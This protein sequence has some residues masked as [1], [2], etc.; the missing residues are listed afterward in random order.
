M[1]SA[2]KTIPNLFIDNAST[3]D[4]VNINTSDLQAPANRITFRD[5]TGAQNG[6]TFN[7]N[8]DAPKTYGNIS[9]PNDMTARFNG[10]QNPLTN[11]ST[12]LPE[13]DTNIFGGTVNF[14][15]NT[16][17]TWNSD[18]TFKD[19]VEIISTPTNV[20]RAVN[21]VRNNIFTVDAPLTFT[22]PGWARVGF[23]ADNTFTE[24]G[25]AVAFNGTRNI[26]RFDGNGNT[27]L[28][29][30]ST[31]FVNSNGGA[32]A[33]VDFRS[34][35]TFEGNVEFGEA[36]GGDATAE[37]FFNNGIS[38]PNI[39]TTFTMGADSRMRI[40]GAPVRLRD[41]IIGENNEITFNSTVEID[42]M[43]LSKFDVIN[44]PQSSGGANS[45]TTT[46]NEY[47]TAR[48]DCAGWINLRS[49]L[50][51]VQAQID[52]ETAHTTVGNRNFL[53]TFVQDIWNRDLGGNPLQVVQADPDV[54]SDIG[55]NDGITFINN[56]AS[57]TFYWVRSDNE[58]ANNQNSTGNWNDL[59]QD[60][61]WATSSGGNAVG[62]IPTA[63]D[64]VVFDDNSFSYTEAGQEPEVV[65]LDKFFSYAK[66]ITWNVTSD[67]SRARL[68]GD[69]ANTLQIFG[70]LL[71]QNNITDADWNDFEGLTEFKGIA[72]ANTTKTIAMNGARLNGPILFNA[73]NDVWTITDNMRVEGGGR[74]DITFNYGEVRA[75]NNTISLEDNWTINLP[76]AGLNQSLFI[77][78]TSTV[79]F[80]GNQDAHINILDHQT[81]ANCLEC[82][83]QSAATSQLRGCS[84]SPFYN[85]VVDKRY[86][87][88]LELR[89]TINIYNNLSILV[90]ILE[91]D[92]WQIRGNTIGTVT[93]ADNTWLRLGADDNATA[94]PTCYPSANITLGDGN[95]DGRMNNSL[96]PDNVTTN[97]KASIVEYRCPDAQL[98]R[99]D[100]TY[101]TLRLRSDGGA[102]AG[103]HI[104]RFTD[105]NT[106]INGSF[107]IDERQ[108]VYDMGY[109]IIGNSFSEGNR[110]EMRGN[111]QLILG[112]NQ[113]IAERTYNITVR[114]GITIPTPVAADLVTTFPSFTNGVY[115][116]ERHRKWWQ[117]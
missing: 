109:Q 67:A 52:F 21:F 45:G 19:D 72:T 111:S 117:N 71:F 47:I 23:N 96:N 39:N 17:V 64:N 5:I 10:T 113:T 116:Y 84:G 106:T 20:D 35:A 78:E 94:F 1:G 4:V 62:C 56:V 79:N 38:M 74:A 12:T 14:G 15:T 63:N 97:L 58:K 69:D 107:I 8:G 41:M 34:Q 46:I 24:F 68:I 101:G 51:G 70:S 59:D 114:P 91:D 7:V 13:T 57:R 80:N 3:G 22:G 37:M 86:N 93:M 89:Q 31:L 48:E 50:T 100:I 25:A 95:P 90:G 54:V 49:N 18:N 87:R 36:T 88:R 92:G 6:L 108:I 102:G 83:D 61:H 115:S 77:A 32:Q 2:A 112:T 16:R 110:F 85:L 28:I 105:G 81:N 76:T 44:F 66:N 82:S 26:L 60:N 33:D 98:V 42:N 29:F 73:P 103:N 104:K 65:T 30:K 53:Y 11:P 99:G 75:G 27:E 43:Q 40:R 55:N 9:F